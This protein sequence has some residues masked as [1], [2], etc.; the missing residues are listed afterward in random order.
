MEKSTDLHF[1]KD[2][3]I[4]PTGL[5]LLR[6]VACAAMRKT[7]PPFTATS[8]CAFPD[9]VMNNW[10]G[11][12]IRFFIHLTQFLFDSVANEGYGLHFFD[13]NS[14]QNAN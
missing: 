6:I 12:A 10:R 3:Y 14:F 11:A 5:S 2:F 7:P 13:S 4:V 9:K 1:I 8:T